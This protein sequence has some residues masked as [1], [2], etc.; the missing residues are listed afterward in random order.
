M[1]GITG[2]TGT[3]GTTGITGV[4]GTTGMTAKPISQFV[5]DI[6]HIRDELNKAEDDLYDYRA[7][8]NAVYDNFVKRKKGENTKMFPIVEWARI[9]GLIHNRD[10]LQRLY[11]KIHTFNTQHLHVR[12]IPYRK[13]KKTSPNICSIC[14]EKHTYRE[15]LTTSCR[16]SFGKECF[17]TLITTCINQYK[18]VSCPECRSSTFELRKY[19]LLANR[20]K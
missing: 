7:T 16:H 4:T 9:T 1:A 12:K 2:I 10:N 19:K 14:L 3:T 6:R 15:L 11:S 20:K 8:F 5:N 13:W 17:H 18:N